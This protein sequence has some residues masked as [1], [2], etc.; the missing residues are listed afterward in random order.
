[1]KT[2]KLKVLLSNGAEVF[3]NTVS[4]SLEAAAAKLNLEYP[5]NFGY[6]VKSIA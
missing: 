2:F 5:N 4:S 3:F 6:I 1:M